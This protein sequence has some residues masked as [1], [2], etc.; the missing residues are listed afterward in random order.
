MTVLS[1]LIC[2]PL[3]VLLTRYVPQL[4]GKPAQ[5]GPLLGPLIQN[6]A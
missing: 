6:K 2:L 1:L 4:M 3:V 5:D